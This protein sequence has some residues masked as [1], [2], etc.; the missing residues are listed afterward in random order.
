M[1]FYFHTVF[2]F[3]FLLSIK[4]HEHS[5][6]VL[7]PVAPCIIRNGYGK[8]IGRFRFIKAVELIVVFKPYRLDL[9]PCNSVRIIRVRLAYRDFTATFKG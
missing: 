3:T 7:S 8:S 9:Q 1:D 6:C 5:H 4:R 2:L